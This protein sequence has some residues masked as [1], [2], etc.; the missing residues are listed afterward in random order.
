ME[1]RLG[2]PRQGLCWAA[3][4]SL[5]DGEWRMLASA[6]QLQD[7]DR[8]VSWAH[9]NRDNGRDKPRILWAKTHMSYGLQI[10]KCSLLSVQLSF[11]WKE[12]DPWSSHVKIPGWRWGTMSFCFVQG[13]QP[14]PSPTPNKELLDFWSVSHKVNAHMG[15]CHFECWVPGKTNEWL[16]LFGVV[17]VVL[18]VHWGRNK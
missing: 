12:N 17:F 6:S 5:H 11:S 16:H 15:S 3:Q 8:N 4:Y 18:N 9:L 2:G 7:E 14:H 1:V 13:L 10:L